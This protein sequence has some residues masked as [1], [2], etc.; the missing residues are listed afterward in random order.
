[1]VVN[2]D[3]DHQIPLLHKPL[4]ADELEIGVPSRVFT[5]ARGHG[6]RD[7][8][9]G[10]NPCHCVRAHLPSKRL[11][12]FQILCGDDRQFYR[13]L[14]H[15]N[16]CTLSSNS[17]SCAKFKLLSYRPRKIPNSQHTQTFH[18]FPISLRGSS[19]PIPKLPNFHKILCSIYKVTKI[20]KRNYV[21]QLGMRRTSA[22][23][24]QEAEDSVPNPMFS[25]N[26]QQKSASTQ[27]CLTRNLMDPICIH[28]AMFAVSRYVEAP[29]GRTC[30][31]KEPAM[32]WCG[33]T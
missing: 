24:V 1:M 27:T 18:N 29:S 13:P 16:R 8:H 30:E 15:V 28:Q 3:G 20:S 9:V 2:V 33:Q 5:S 31:P 10:V 26:I 23:L 32:K 25:T 12:I 22:F 11:H 6:R 19:K 7:L 17:S 21:Q 4:F 14:L